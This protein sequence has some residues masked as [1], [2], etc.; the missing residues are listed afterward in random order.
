MW[1]W[2][3]RNDAQLKIVFAVVAALYVLFEYR[4]KLEADRLQR[5]LDYISRYDQGNLFEANRKLSKFWLSSEVAEWEMNVEK[6]HYHEEL[7]VLLQGHSLVDEAYELLMFYRNA[8][9]CARTTLCKGE[10]ICRF[11]FSDVQD[12]RETYRGLLVTWRQTWGVL[13]HDLI[14][15][16]P[17]CLASVYTPGWWPL[18]IAGSFAVDVE[19][20]DDVGLPVCAGG[21]SRCTSGGGHTPGSSRT[22]I[23]RRS[24]SRRV[25]C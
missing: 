7:A 5:S 14:Q 4:G 20:R 3:K 24:W 6:D 18:L 15:S 1:S 2:I 19:G 25:G 21:R 8:S 23:G 9:I 12:F 16:D 10:T 22:P 13:L 11:F 17:N